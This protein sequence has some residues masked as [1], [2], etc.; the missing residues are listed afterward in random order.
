M[1]GIEDEKQIRDLIAKFIVAYK[2]GDLTAILEY[3]SADLVKQRQGSSAET[4]PE[5]ANRIR[6]VF[7][8]YKTDIEVT[9]DEI[10]VSGNLAFVRGDFELTLTPKNGEETRR[11]PRHYLEIWRKEDGVWRV[12]RTMDN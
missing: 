11:I 10:V 12:F 1:S 6:G 2:A 5:T 4:K 9:I 8:E 7:E 3:Y